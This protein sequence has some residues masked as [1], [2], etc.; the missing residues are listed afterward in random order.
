MQLGRVV[1]TDRGRDSTL[2]QIARRGE[3]RTLGQKNDVGLGGGAKRSVH[4][5]DSTADDDQLCAL[6]SHRAS[7]RP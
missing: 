2:G 7:F 6:C 4:A 3:Q 1:L 5:G